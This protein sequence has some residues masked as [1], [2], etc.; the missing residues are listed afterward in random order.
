MPL[1]VRKIVKIAKKHYPDFELGK[2][3]THTYPAT[4]TSIPGSMHPLGAHSGTKTPIEN[5]NIRQMCEELDMEIK[6]FLKS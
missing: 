4:R 2:K 6:L 3:G 1:K 5:R